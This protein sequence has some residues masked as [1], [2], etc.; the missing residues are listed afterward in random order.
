MIAIT[1][2]SYRQNLILLGLSQLT[3]LYNARG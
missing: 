1:N 3:L 2:S